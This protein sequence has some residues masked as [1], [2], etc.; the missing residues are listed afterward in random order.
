MLEEKTYQIY[1]KIAK[2]KAEIYL[3]NIAIEKMDK[4][5]RIFKSIILVSVFFIV[6]GITYILGS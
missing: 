3:I 4:E 2:T 5:A 6:F 1:R